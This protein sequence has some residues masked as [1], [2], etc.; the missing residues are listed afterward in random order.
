M[1]T[2]RLLKHSVRSE[3][4]PSH[5]CMKGLGI[6]YAGIWLPSETKSTFLLSYCISTCPSIS[7][8]EDRKTPL[9]FKSIHIATSGLS[10]S[11]K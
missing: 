3:G 5:Q 8:A 4:Q 9:D 2:R 1:A 10:L 7:G 6:A 11:R